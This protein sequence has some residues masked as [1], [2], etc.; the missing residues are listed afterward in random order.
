MA[1]PLFGP[2][3]RMMLL[4]KNAPGMKAFVETLNPTTVADV[5]AGDSFSSEEVWEVLQKAD[6]RVQAKVFEYF[7]MEWQ[8]KLA[9]GAGR[10]QMA[11][12]VELMSHDDRVNLLRRLPS[13]VS[14]ALL[15]LVDDADRRDI[16][17]LSRYGENTVGAI[18]TTDYAWL[19]ADLTAQQAIERLRAQAPDRETIYYVYIVDEQTRKMLGILTLRALVLAEPSTPIRRLM[20]TDDVVTLRASADRETAADA[21]RRYGLIAIPVLDDEGRLVGIV[22][23]D[24]IVEV[25]SEEATEDLQRQGAVGPFRGNYLQTGLFTIWRKRAG[26]LCLLFGAELATFT[27]MAEF[28]EALQT[29][30]VLSLFVPL[31]LSTGGNSGSQAATIITRELALGHIAVHDWWRVLRHEILMGGLLGITLGAIGFL[32]GSSTSEDLRSARKEMESPIEVV[33]P[34]DRPFGPDARGDYEVAE[35]TPIAAR[36]PAK[37]K[38]HIHPPGNQP[39]DQKVAD[40]EIVY[41]FPAGTETHTETVG[42]WRFGLV[43]ALSVS[44]ICLWGTLIGSM[45]P[46]VFN[47][48]GADP[49]LASSPFVAT[50]V[51][52]TGI[53]AYFTIATLLL[54]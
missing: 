15:R 6:P 25:I 23:H 30:L 11:R 17:A 49:A 32:R 19:P 16:A 21:L 18:M 36:E 48:V 29:I 38:T 20:L 10:P 24:D 44:F 54:F 13:Q 33:L 46:L 35:G 41:T 37:R 22:T 53:L 42:R 2:E 26:W 40:G 52:V 9:E 28:D 43:I 3:V 34:S 5:L 47:Q 14:D 4:E 31:C 7:P 39:P 51:D 1:H 27:A 50:F 45:L 8:V 12:L